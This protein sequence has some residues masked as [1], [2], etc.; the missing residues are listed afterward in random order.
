MSA[1]TWIAIW[2]VAPMITAPVTA[3][4]TFRQTQT[5]AYTRY[6]LLDPAMHR[7]RIVYDV[8][9]TAAG[10]R[11]F[12]NPI[13]RGSEETVHRV[14]DLLNGRALPWDVV[15]GADASVDGM[16]NADSAAR[17]IRVT[18]P[19]PVPEGGQVRLRIDK[20]YRDPTSYGPTPEGLRFSRSLGIRRNAVVLP[21]G[22]ELTGVNYPSQVVRESDGRLKVSFLNVGPS[23]V[24]FVIVGRPLPGSRPR[25]VAE[26]RAQVRPVRMT[27][28][29]VPAGARVGYTFS[30]RAFQ[31]RDI[32][33]FLRD[34]A[35]HAFRLYH[36]YTERRLGVDRYLN[37]VRAGS[38]ASDPSAV[39][40]DTGDSLPVETLRGAEIVERGLD[41][42]QEITPATEVVVIRFPAV[43]PGHSV[44]LRIAE[45]YADPERYQVVNDELVWDRSFGRPR[46]TVVLPEGW[47]LTANAVPAVVTRLDD[48]RIRLRYVNDRPGV[49]GVFIRARRR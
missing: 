24:P 30:E 28:R 31:D 43:E 49:I 1:R 34:P 19:R 18:L 35:T 12:F 40:L 22:Y 13:R 16:L 10:A 32:T 41:I 27:T 21:V 42:G 23:A 33:Y 48:G 2:V 25:T 20:T 7:F 46:N 39:V 47:Y 38:R 37:V 9:A 15:N 29:S 45:T 8:S 11:F 6:E 14:I 3:R 4:Q 44:R 5:D 17:Y 36:D 26:D